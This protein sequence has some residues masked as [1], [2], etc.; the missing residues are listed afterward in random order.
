MECVVNGPRGQPTLTVSL[1][2]LRV[3][4]AFTAPNDLGVADHDV[5]LP[6]GQTFHNPMRVLPDGEGSELVFTVRRAP[7]VTDEAFE[8][9][10]AT[11]AGDLETARGILE[12][13]G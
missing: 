5:T 11:V 7:G 12:S 4:V 3:V 1:D 8:T 9:D 2:V 13:R 6:G 10:A